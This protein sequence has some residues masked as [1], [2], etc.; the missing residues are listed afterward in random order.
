MFRECFFFKKGEKFSERVKN[1]GVGEGSVTTAMAVPLVGTP[2]LADT[3]F[4]KKI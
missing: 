1:R 3:N 2:K 4:F